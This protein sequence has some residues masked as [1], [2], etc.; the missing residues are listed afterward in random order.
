MYSFE[1]LTHPGDDLDMAPYCT[2]T[3]PGLRLMLHMLA[4]DFPIMA[5]GASC[6]KEAVGLALASTKPDDS[7]ARVLSIYVEPEHRN[8]GVGTRLLATLEEVVSARACQRLSLTYFD[9]LPTA[10]ALE[11]ILARNRWSDPEVDMV[12]VKGSDEVGRVVVESEWMKKKRTLPS[13]YEIFLW[14]ELTAEEREAIIRR[15]AAGPW[16]PEELSP[17]REAAIME[18]L[19][20]LGLR[21]QGE[22]VGWLV[23]HRIGPETIR[24]TPLFISQ[25]ARSVSAA[26]MLITEAIRLQGQAG[27]YNFLFLFKPDSPIRKWA[28]RRFG[29]LTTICNVMKSHKVINIPQ[30]DH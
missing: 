1:Q 28:V 5:V 27:I 18:P 11:Q 20:S 8:V 17:F 6:G 4:E 16:Y 23:N 2:M 30:A 10:G 24:Y 3:F 13:G 19:N 26:F 9:V 12:M 14:S 22:V 21:Y 15:Q 29:D 25:E 7:S